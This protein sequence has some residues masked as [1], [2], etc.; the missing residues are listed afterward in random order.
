M[1][2]SPS[3]VEYESATGYHDIATDSG[4]DGGSADAT[5]YGYGDVFR[6]DAQE[7]YTFMSENK[8]G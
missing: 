8:V 4:N 2:P 7:L 5:P 6:A 1:S 3:T